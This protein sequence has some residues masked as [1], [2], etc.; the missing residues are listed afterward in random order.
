MEDEG[1]A[2]IPA[3]SAGWADSPRAPGPPAP[4][5][6][7]CPL[8]KPFPPLSVSRGR[9]PGPRPSKATGRGTAVN[10]LW[11]VGHTL[12]TPTL[13]TSLNCHPP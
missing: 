6:Y 12:G 10:S 11:R 13:G 1:A 8:G 5:L 7:Q 3:L 2:G 9:S 4:G